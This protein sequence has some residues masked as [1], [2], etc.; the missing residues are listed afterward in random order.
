M[1]LLTFRLTEQGTFSAHEKKQACIRHIPVP[2]IFFATDVAVMAWLNHDEN[3]L[4]YS[5]QVDYKMKN[6]D[7]M[8]PKS[9]E[10]WKKWAE[11]W[12]LQIQVDYKNWL[13]K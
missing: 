4:N 13:R 3:K 7:I 2:A 1:A 12:A 8:A 6:D 9:S 5:K 10:R 11:F